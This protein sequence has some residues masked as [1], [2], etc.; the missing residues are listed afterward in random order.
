[1]HTRV[2]THKC[3]S[4]PGK[5]RALSSKP[6]GS[7]S[8]LAQGWRAKVIPSLWTK[9]VGVRG[10]C[11]S[12]IPLPAPPLIQ[13]WD[14][15][16]LKSTVPCEKHAWACSDGKHWKGKWQNR[17][18]AGLRRLPLCA[19]RTGAEV[20]ACTWWL[21]PKLPTLESGL[22]EDPVFLI[23]SATGSYTK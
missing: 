10:L 11:N 21:T 1:M 8:C 14:N 6:A 18:S 12:A 3:K 17:D 13:A 7:F 9:V 20:N 22:E 15:P 16:G 19:V 2:N 4:N 23:P 5:G